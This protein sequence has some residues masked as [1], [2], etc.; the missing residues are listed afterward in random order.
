MP[1]A[2]DGVLICVGRDSLNGY[3]ISLVDAG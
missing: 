1:F 2:H 3:C